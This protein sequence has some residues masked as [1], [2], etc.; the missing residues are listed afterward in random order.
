LLTRQVYSPEQSREKPAVQ[1]PASLGN[2]T[3]RAEVTDV[4]SGKVVLTQTLRRGDALRLDENAGGPAGASDNTD[5]IKGAYSVR[6]ENASGRGE[7]QFVVGDLRE[8]KEQLENRL[9]RLQPGPK[10][11]INAGTL[12]RR[13]EILFEPENYKLDDYKWRE[14][15][16]Y[17]ICSLAALLGVL[18]RGNPDP[19]RD[20]P[21]LHIRGFAS[22]LDAS[23]QHY[24][25]YVPGTYQRGQK[26]PLLA[27]MPTTISASQLPFIES[28]FVANHRDTVQ[29]S[30]VAERYG[31]ALLWS[32]YRNIPAGLPCENAHLDEVLKAVQEDY[33]LDLG[34]IHLYGVCS[35]GIFAGNAAAKWPNRFAAIIYN[36]A[37]FLRTD[38]TMTGSVSEQLK[39][40][41]GMDIVEAVLR[42]ASISVFVTNTENAVEGHG[43]IELS[44]A[45]IA[46]A[47]ALGKNVV[48]DMSSPPGGESIWD[49]VFLWAARC[50]LEH[51]GGEAADLGSS[52]GYAGPVR[53]VF[54]T[55]VIIVQGTTGSDQENEEIRRFCIAIQR[56]YKEHFY[57]ASCGIR[58]DSDLSEE[59]IGSR[60]DA[61]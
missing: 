17:A 52:L 12:L 28:P 36:R 24:R 38:E 42:N 61:S 26:L 14:K 27:I 10:A 32:G 23:T 8:L 54:A 59:D 35:G 51:P 44:R 53:E 1:W 31:F 5:T 56:S 19:A 30:R 47:A 18:E 37:I 29:M 16:A 39:W 25:L 55:P 7:E 43:E 34:R 9:K 57:L 22:S 6:F 40:T 58:R 41:A 50:K 13:L 21:G 49:R 33:D 3:V 45:F 20:A 46:R 48:A 15:T 60:G 4:F 2:M 11:R